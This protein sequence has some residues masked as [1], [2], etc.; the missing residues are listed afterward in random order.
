MKGQLNLSIILFLL[1]SIVFSQNLKINHYDFN[2]ELLPEL[3][4]LLANVTVK[5]ISQDSNIVKQFKVNLNFNKLI[6][7]TDKNGK[8]L[9]YNELNKFNDIEDNLL[10]KLNDPIKQNDTLIFNIKYEGVINSWNRIAIKNSWLTSEFVFYPQL[11]NQTFSD[12]FTFNAKITVP[13]SMVVISTGDL[14]KLDTLKNKTMFN[15]KTSKPQLLFTLSAGYYSIHQQT[16]NNIKITTYLFPEHQARSDTLI[17]LFG[18]VLSF[19]QEQFGEYPLSEFKIVETNRRGGYSPKGLM[20]LNSKSINNLDDVSHF[21]IAHEVAHQWFPHRIMF[22]PQWY[23][24][25][26][27]AQYAA[28]SYFKL[29]LKNFNKIKTMK[30]LFMDL[31]FKY[32]DFF[33]LAYNQVYEEKP[34][35]EISFGDSGYRWAAYYKAFYFLNGLASTLGIDT[36]NNLIKTL[37]ENNQLNKI[38]LDEFTK[39][40]ADESN[41]DISN[42]VHDFIYTNKILDYDIVDV[43]SQKTI[44]GK[45][46]TNVKIKNH[47]NL[48]TPVEVVAVSDSNKALTKKIKRFYENEANVEFLSDEKITKIEID[49]NSYTLD[50]NRINNYYPRK[51]EFSFLFSTPNYSMSQY[52]YYPSLTYSKRDNFRLGLWFSNIFPLELLSKNIE[53]IKW[54]TGLFYGFASKRI[55]YYIDFETVLGMPSYRWNW[56]MNLSNYMGTENYSLSTNYIFQKD[57]NHGKHNI[58]SV[59]ANRNLIYDIAYYDDKDFENGTNNTLSFNWDRKLYDEKENITMKFGGKFLGSNY[60]YARISM[61]LENFLPISFNWLKYRIFGGL[62]T[63]SYPNKNQYIYRVVP[64]LQVFLIGLLTQVIIFQPKKIC[65]QKEMQIYVVILVNI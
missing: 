35:S 3:H 62:I 26:S 55:G 27:F 63:G 50:A 16:K 9:K 53:P 33:R 2:F 11:E 51:R 57:D 12:R 32:D 58:I 22:S 52:F 21:I 47:W 20:L 23:L 7:I 24:N 45:Y 48:F 41:Q 1:S 29:F 15:Y 37:I 18:D 30:F 56:G 64:I 38:S 49:P 19:Y 34:V 25:E 6:S 39:Y 13:D 4:K 31:H 28:F 65:T 14:I 54:R 8:N 46:R 40:L 42:L 17:K 59:S 36:F 61:E 44:E 10:I 60:S 43:K 5:A